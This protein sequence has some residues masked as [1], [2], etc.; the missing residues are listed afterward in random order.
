MPSPRPHRL[1]THL[2]QLDD[3]ITPAGNITTKMVSGILTISSTD[4]GQNNQNIALLGASEGHVSI[5][6]QDGE[7]FTGKNSFNHVIRVV[8]KMGNGNDTV[9][10]VDLKLS[11]RGS[12]VTFTGG[13]GNNSLFFDGLNIK[14][15]TLKATSGTGNFTVV[16]GL[17]L[18]AFGQAKLQAT[19]QELQEEKAA[20]QELIG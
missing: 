7:T 11:K 1:R 6:A 15:D 13:N 2:E 20:V 14:I 10:C 17:K 8:I 16:Q 12:G 3:R 18:D 19:L 4:G 5:S 9:T